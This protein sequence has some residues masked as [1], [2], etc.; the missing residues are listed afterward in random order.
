MQQPVES[1][2][3]KRPINN[4]NIRTD[5]TLEV[6]TTIPTIKCCPG[7][8]IELAILA[9]FVIIGIAGFIKSVKTETGKNKNSRAG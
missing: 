2:T 3:V 8:Y 7:F 6:N 9:L 1:I 5:T 4:D